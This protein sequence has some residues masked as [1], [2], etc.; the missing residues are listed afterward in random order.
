MA[1]SR[2]KFNGIL[3][4]IASTG[5]KLDALIADGIQYCVEQAKE[6]GNFDNFDKLA[7]ACP[8]YARKLVHDAAK[9]ARETHKLRS[10]RDDAPELARET[11][12]D[13]LAQRREKTAAQRKRAKSP[14]QTEPAAPEVPKVQQVETYKLIHIVG[15]G[16]G[17][18]D[19]MELSVE[20]FQAAKAAIQALR[21]E[22]GKLK[23][24]NG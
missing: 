21:E 18:D 22:A 20:E 4:S 3:K 23:V 16:N 1:I 6:H 7:T 8:V 14:P 15:A 13:E 2:A 9:T 24:A 11:A 10:W 17:H 19:I 5:S 12:V